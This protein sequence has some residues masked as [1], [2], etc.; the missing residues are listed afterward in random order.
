M[1]AIIA[2]VVITPAIAT[3]I[4]LEH[5]AVKAAERAAAGQE[6]GDAK[7]VNVAVLEDLRPSAPLWQRLQ[8]ALIEIDT[9]GLLLLGF[10]WSLVSFHCFTH[11]WRCGLLI[12]CLSF[13]CP[14][15]SKHMQTMVI[16]IVLLLP[17]LWLEAFCSSFT[18]SGSSS[19]LHF[20][21]SLCGSSVRVIKY[22]SNMVYTDSFQ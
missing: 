17:C 19:L 2:P 22:I 13:S 5:R 12:S 14:F 6:I 16:Q 20:Q 11:R 15:H 3:M 21:P 4:W 18:P 7:D 8:K 9:F 1:F 10:G